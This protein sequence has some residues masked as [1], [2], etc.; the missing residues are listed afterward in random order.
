MKHK[1]I[2]EKTSDKSIKQVGSRLG[3]LYGLGEIYQETP[4]GLPI[5]VPILSDT[6]KPTYKSTKLMNI[7]LMNIL[8]MIHLT[9]QK[10]L[11]FLL[12]TF[13][14]NFHNILKHNFCSLFNLVTKE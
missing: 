3:I 9:L 1:E 11:I 7:Q 10:K 8:S 5:F 13:H 14:E 6:G 12:T 4:H 2:I